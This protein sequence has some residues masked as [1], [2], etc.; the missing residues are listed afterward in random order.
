MTPPLDPGG[1][2]VVF[3]A[4]GLVPVVVQ[5]ADSD[6]VLMLAF[7]NAEALEA[8]QRTGQAHYWSRSRARL[9]RK[10]ETSGNAQHVIDLRINCEQNS[11]LLRVHQVGAVCHDGY[12][13]CFYRCLNPDNSL[14]IEQE[15]VFDP[16]EIYGQSGGADSSLVTSTKALFAAYLYLYEHDL[17]TVSRTSRRLRSGAESANGRLADELRELAGVLDGTHAHTQHQEDIRLEAS[18]V[19]YWVIIRALQVGATWD[20]IRP[21]VALKSE[22]SDIPPNLLATLLRNDA[23]FWASATVSEDVGRIAASLH[24]TLALASQACTME[25]ISIS[26]IIE[27]DLTSLRQKPYLAA[28]RTSLRE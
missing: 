13:T 4:Q 19:I 14:A 20:Q 12:A 16:I 26:E 17:S 25:E 11:L 27:A 6:A 8:T 15:R 24:A 5:D 3:D 2:S 1:S 7:M 21:D 10:G 9:W 28:H 18:Q 22:S 23:G